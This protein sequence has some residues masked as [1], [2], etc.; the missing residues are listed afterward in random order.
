MQ[1]NLKKKKQKEISNYTEEQFE[2]EFKIEL[3]FYN[4]PQLLLVFACVFVVAYIFKKYI[5]AVVFLI[6]FFVMRYKFKTTFHY[7][8]ILYC[9]ATTILLFSLS[10]AF[11]P[12]IAVS[13]FGAVLMGF[14]DTWALWFIQDRF[15]LKLFKANSL[16]F[17]L[18]TATEEQII[19]RCK[20]L[21]Y[22]KDK[23]DLAI[24]FF[25]EKLGN[26]QVYDWLCERK[27]YVE[28]ETIAKYRYRMAKDLRQFEK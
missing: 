18:D 19:A 23:I 5:E 1:K 15:D 3:F 27:L 28:Y 22:K 21:H 24:K 12:P 17:S 26:Q 7:E 11:S 14:A 10:V 25:V 9:L 13:L 2:R 20:M 6:T 4:L 16:K 8:N